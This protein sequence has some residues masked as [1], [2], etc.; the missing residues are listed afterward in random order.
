MSPEIIGVILGTL[1]VVPTLYI[2]RKNH[3]EAWAWPIFFV[4]LPVYYMLFGLLVMDRTVI[5][6]EFLWG[7]PFIAT[8]LIAWRF[9]SHLTHYLLAIG[10]LSHGFYDYYHDFLFVN[11]GVFSWYPVFCAL[12]DIVVGAYLLTSSTRIDRSLAASD[13]S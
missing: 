7:L 5:L 13:A 2:V 1:F 9:Q 12:I 10:W 11:E 3:L 8:G 6:S 4:T